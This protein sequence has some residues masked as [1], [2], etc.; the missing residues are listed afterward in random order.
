MRKK[1]GILVLI[2]IL[3]GSV[4]TG[5]IIGRMQDLS[6]AFWPHLIV[7]LFSTLLLTSGNLAVRWFRWNYLIRRAS[8]EIRTR[9]SLLVYFSTLPALIVPFYL[10]E[11]LRVALLHRKYRGRTVQLIMIFFIER[12]M[13]IVALLLFLP[14]R[15]SISAPLAL[16][17]I[18][19]L[20]ILYRRFLAPTT[21]KTVLH[22]VFALFLSCIA[23]VLPVLGLWTI[24]L[25]A[26]SA[27]S[28]SSLAAGFAQSSLITGISG[29]PLGVGLAGS[30]LLGYLTKLG[31]VYEFGVVAVFVFRSATIWY[32]VLLGIL[33][34]LLWHKKLRTLADSLSVAEHFNEIASEYEGLI[35]E[36]VKLRLLNK[37][38][39]RM[40][41]LLDERG[42]AANA[43]GLDFG[44]GQGWYLT[45][46][47]E[48]GYDMSGVDISSNQVSKAMYY[49]DTHGV[50]A[51]IRV[52]NGTQLPFADK[53]FD[54]AYSINVFH[55]ITDQ[56]QRRKAIEEVMRVMKP[57]AVFFLQEVNILNPI[58]RFYMGYIF[59]IL[60]PIDEGTEIWIKPDQL[61]PLKGGKWLGKVEYFTFLPDFVPEFVLK[62]LHGLETFLERSFF[63]KYSAHYMSVLL[64]TESTNY[65]SGEA[66]PSA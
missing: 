52:F 5:A 37:K 59:P 34:I 13:D 57:G 19:L 15:V 21:P 44:C 48:Q 7:G 9:D 56:T 18:L 33:F 36:H 42:F 23:W 39:V 32:S 31:I 2:T 38:I 62:Y 24:L 65:V 28:I 14:F 27:I 43:R 46:L 51:D 54:F 61:P 20:L 6:P 26:Q 47:A 55:H 49:A 12:I 64:R 10:G 63:K 41:S 4:V 16:V 17:L 8:R 40:V 60:R 53:S 45:R 50:R 58:F 29:L 22:V 25:P 35:P 30:L 66:S 1:I 11:L 3:L